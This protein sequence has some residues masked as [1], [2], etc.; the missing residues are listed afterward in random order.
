MKKT[1]MLGMALAL[2]ASTATAMA[3]SS[4]DAP[5]VKKVQADI[6]GQYALATLAKSR[7]G[8]A[9]VRSLAAQ[10]AA[11]TAASND[12][13]IQYAKKHG[14][15]L[16]SKPGFRA[17]AQYGEM[18]SLHGHAFDKRFAEDVYADTQLEGSDFDPSSVSDGSLKAF[19]QKESA[20]F[21]TFGK[22]AHKLG[23]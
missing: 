4:S 3:D 1:F 18:Q 21:S 13:L 22:R 19:A 15:A 12:F 20:A 6:L 11:N 8:D 2:A 5:F 9:E 23:G 7:A 10:V 14:I 17:D 16:T